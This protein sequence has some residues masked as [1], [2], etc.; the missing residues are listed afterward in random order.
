A[1]DEIEIGVDRFID[2][3]GGEWR[4]HVDYRDVRAGGLLRLAHGAEDRDALEILAGL[5]RIDAGDE[6]VATVGV[7]AA[8]AR[9]EL[10]GLAGDALR[11]DFR[12]VVDEDAHVVWRLRSGCNLVMIL[13]GGR[14]H[15]ASRPSG[16]PVSIGS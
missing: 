8:D 9:V 4:W 13:N 15:H 7:L 11:D 1:D 3:G 5:F 2:G 10:P 12:G 6:A 14:H 16:G